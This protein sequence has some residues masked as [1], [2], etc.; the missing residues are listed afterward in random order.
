MKSVKR[1][2]YFSR[3]V[4]SSGVLHQSNVGFIM[5]HMFKYSGKD[6]IGLSRLIYYA[7]E[8]SDKACG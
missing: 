8:I 1:K 7:V 2:N 6:V 4:S 3:R 5:L